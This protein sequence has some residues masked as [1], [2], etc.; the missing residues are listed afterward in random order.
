MTAQA[1]SG[2][3]SA[4]GSISVAGEAKTSAV[5]AI[6]VPDTVSEGQYTIQFQFRTAKGVAL[7]DVVLTLAVSG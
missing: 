1:G 3:P 4:S 5:L 2:I 7:P 6:P